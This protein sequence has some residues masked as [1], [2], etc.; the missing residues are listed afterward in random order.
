MSD[1]MG[2]LFF[3][4]SNVGRTTVVRQN[5]WYDFPVLIF[6]RNLQLIGQSINHGSTNTESGER[7]WTSEER[8][9]REIGPV[10]LIFDKF[11][12][13]KGENLLS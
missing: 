8:D 6:Q 1:G 11:I 7:T 5:D 4:K 13:D 12:M 3:G 9:F 10:G 2:D